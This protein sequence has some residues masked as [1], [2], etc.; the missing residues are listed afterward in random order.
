M[1]QYDN[2]F[3]V[4][5]MICLK[6][7]IFY[8]SSYL[9][10]RVG[11]YTIFLFSTVGRNIAANGLRLQEVGDFEALN[12][13]PAF[14]LLRS[15]KLHLTTEPPIS[16]RCC[17]RLAFLSVVGYNHFYVVCSCHLSS[18]FLFGLCVGCFIFF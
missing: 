3:A 5:V 13:L 14:N 15:T 17:Y 6:E 16:C 7:I 18:A 11:K 2:H 4:A 12:C 10:F 8:I 9:N 1:K